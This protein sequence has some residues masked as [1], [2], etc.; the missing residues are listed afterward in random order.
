[1]GKLS[2]ILKTTFVVC[3]LLQLTNLSAQVKLPADLVEKMKKYHVRFERSILSQ[4]TDTLLVGYSAFISN[5]KG[6][7]SKLAMFKNPAKKINL[8]YY[9]DTC[10]NHY[11]LESEL[12]NDMAGLFGMKEE[13]KYSIVSQNEWSV[14]LN[15]DDVQMAVL[16]NQ[17]DFLKPFTDYRYTVIIAYYNNV[18][19]GKIYTIIN[20]D[21]DINDLLNAFIK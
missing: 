19:K 1:M 15:A 17:P 9:I 4:K 13:S 2:F 20:F 3:L 6:I 8:A 21:S 10:Y 5:K 16:K 11:N 12:R 14:L 7:M 18:T